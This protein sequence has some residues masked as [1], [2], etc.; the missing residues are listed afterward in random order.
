[1]NRIRRSESEDPAFES[2]LSACESYYRRQ[3]LVSEHVTES[4][5]GAAG[6]GSDMEFVDRNT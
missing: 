3:L 2:Y 6:D 4:G 1:M 5:Y